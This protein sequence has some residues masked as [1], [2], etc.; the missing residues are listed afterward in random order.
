MAIWVNTQ[1]RMLEI[2][3]S[4]GCTRPLRYGDRIVQ[5]VRGNCY[6]GHITPAYPT[7]FGEWHFECFKEFPL[8]PQKMPY[9]CAKCFERIEHGEN[10]A[11]FLIG[12]KPADG[13]S[14]PEL[15]GDKLYTVAHL[16]HFADGSS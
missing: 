12:Y 10:I 4:E 13:Y 1:Q 15:R 14:R 3:M 2:C 7:I 8:N 6:L 5:M 11:C 9:R 16:R